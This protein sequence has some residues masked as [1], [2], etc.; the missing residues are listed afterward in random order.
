MLRKQVLENEIQRKF[1]PHKNKDIH[2]IKDHILLEKSHIT[3][4]R[5]IEEDKLTGEI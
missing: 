4:W 3:M 5:G 2:P 1:Q